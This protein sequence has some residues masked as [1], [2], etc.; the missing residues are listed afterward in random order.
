MPA[1]KLFSYKL[2]YGSDD[3]VLPGAFS[4]I[5]RFIWLIILIYIL[6]KHYN[7]L[8]NCQSLNGSP[9]PKINISFHTPKINI[10]FKYY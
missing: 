9:P 5:L 3:L 7:I 6:I 4:S 8:S 10:S 1:L 2:Q